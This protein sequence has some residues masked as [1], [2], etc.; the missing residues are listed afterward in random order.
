MEK[1]HSERKHERVPTEVAV[2]L[3]NGAEGITRDLSPTGVFFLAETTLGEGDE[4]HFSIEFDNPAGP[5]RME[6]VGNIVRVEAMAA[7]RGFAVR[8]TESRL[9]RGE[10]AG[11]PAAAARA[12]GRGRA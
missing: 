11:M 6:C 7:K 3:E 10:E 2:H 12:P 4:I 9:A 5:L 1:K 8:I